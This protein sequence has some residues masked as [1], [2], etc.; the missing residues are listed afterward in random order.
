MAT[1]FLQWCLPL[2]NIFT[3]Y[4]DVNIRQFHVYLS[5]LRPIHCKFGI[6]TEYFISNYWHLPPSWR[7]DLSWTK[8]TNSAPT[9]SHQKHIFE[10]EDS[11]CHIYALFNGMQ[12]ISQTGKPHVSINKQEYY[13]INYDI[14]MIYS[15][16]LHFDSLWKCM[17]SDKWKPISSPT[18]HAHPWS[19]VLLPT[20][21]ASAGN[22]YT[23]TKP[24]QPATLPG[25]H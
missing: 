21:W 6:L 9:C 1:S 15:L 10:K 12:I 22:R 23:N 4:S 3:K 19:L 20:P 18:C 2:A 11:V 25:K 13:Y 16:V 24:K 17:P 7:C 8:L 14:A 5:A